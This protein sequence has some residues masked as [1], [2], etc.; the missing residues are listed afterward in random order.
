MINE[1]KLRGFGST[2]SIFFLVEIHNENE[3]LSVVVFPFKL[4]NDESREFLSPPVSVL[5]GS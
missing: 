4:H 3:L 2:G 1:R 5:V